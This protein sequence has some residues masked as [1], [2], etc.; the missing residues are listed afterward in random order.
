MHKVIFKINKFGDKAIDRDITIISL[1]LD[2]E[3]TSKDEVKI[4]E[5][6][7]D[8]ILGN[9]EFSITRKVDSIQK[10]EDDIC[11]IKIVFLEL[12]RLKPKR[13]IRKNAVYQ[14]LYQPLYPPNPNKIVKNT[15]HYDDSDDFFADI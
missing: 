9:E 13:T 6:G 11:Y 7:T 10:L 1:E 2:L 3:Y 8:F 4:P 12:T 14:P 15:I 5:V